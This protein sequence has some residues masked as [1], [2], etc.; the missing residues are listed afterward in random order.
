MVTGRY[1]RGKIL[2]KGHIKPKHADSQTK[3]TGPESNPPKSLRA[4]L[5]NWRILPT[6]LEEIFFFFGL[7]EFSNSSKIPR[8]LFVGLPSGPVDARIL[9]VTT[10]FTYSHIS[11]PIDQ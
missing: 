6:L 4:G 10:V 1:K 2:K 11:T 9:D 8:R 7:G 5:E 3:S